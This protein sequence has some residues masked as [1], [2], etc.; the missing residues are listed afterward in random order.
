MSGLELKVAPDVVWLLVAAS[1]WLSSALTRG[2]AVPAA[3]RIVLAGSF[4]AA[5]IALIVA[6][7]VELDRAHTTWHPSEPGRTTSLVT[8]GAFRCSR[9]PTYLGMWLVLVGWAVVLANLLAL[10]VTFAFMLYLT[11]FQ[12]VPEERVLSALLGDQYRQYAS[13]VR[14]WL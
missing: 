14:R 5:G 6:A 10:A 7:R 8:A 3:V 11:R 4:F 9:N 2:I 13:Q 1:M 12:I